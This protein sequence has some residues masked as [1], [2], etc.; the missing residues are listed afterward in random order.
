MLLL[1]G[2]RALSLPKRLRLFCIIS[3]A[4]VILGL[5]GLIFFARPPGYATTIFLP[6]GV[7]VGSAFLFRAST[8]PSVFVGSLVLNLLIGLIHSQK[9]DL[10]GF[11][12]AALIA[13]CS[14][15]QGGIGGWL[16]RVHLKFHNYSL[17][18]FGN[19]VRFTLLAPSI[20]LISATLSNGCLWMLGIVQSS[21]VVSNWLEW[22]M[23]DTFGVLVLLPWM[24][25]LFPAD[26][27]IEMWTQDVLRGDV[28]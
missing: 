7:A 10:L 20:C 14:T 11:E 19:I 17:I 6:S 25:L 15:I 21:G 8:L 18:N 22:Y 1:R 12:A 28:K 27:Q 4:Y 3:I 13:A 16:F 24:L 9:F 26:E 23:G 5:F 2:I